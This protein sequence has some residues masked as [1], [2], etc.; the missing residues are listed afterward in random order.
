MIVCFNVEALLRFFFSDLRL[1]A[2]S[3]EVNR[4]DILLKNL[5]A[6]GGEAMICGP[7]G[8][9]TLKIEARKLKTTQTTGRRHKACIEFWALYCF[10]CVLLSVLVRW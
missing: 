10:S 3:W 4:Q 8:R 7:A 1:L 6:V 2:G 9:G 5:P